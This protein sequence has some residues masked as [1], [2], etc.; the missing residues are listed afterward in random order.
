MARAAFLS[1]VMAGLLEYA[2]GW[3]VGRY[4][5]PTDVGMAVLGGIAGALIARHGVNLAVRRRVA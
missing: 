4:P 3:I 5:D 1:C 2:Q